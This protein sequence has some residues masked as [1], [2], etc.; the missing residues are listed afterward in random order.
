[1]EEGVNRRLAF[2]F[3]A[4]PIKSLN[5]KRYRYPHF[6]QFLAFPHHNHYLIGRNIFTMLGTGFIVMH[7]RLIKMRKCN[8]SQKI[9]WGYNRSAP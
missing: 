7:D 3:R 8:S 5:T 1:V 2:T 6:G 4:T 9:K